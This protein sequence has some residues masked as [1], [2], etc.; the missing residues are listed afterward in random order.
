M[1]P[2]TVALSSL[3]TAACSPTLTPSPVDAGPVEPALHGLLPI[4]SSYLDRKWRAEG[5]LITRLDDHG[6]PVRFGARTDPLVIEARRFYDTL[7]RPDA[8]TTPVDY[9]DPFT[10]E[11]HITRATAPVSLDE[12]KQTFGFPLWDRAGGEPLARYRERVRAVVYYNKHELGLG[13]ELACATFADGVDEG[14]RALTGIACYVTN[15]GAAFDDRHN[16]LAAAVAGVSPKNTVCITY[17]PSFEPGYQVQFYVYAADGKRLEWAEL[18]GQGPRPVPH[19]CMSCHG[20][21]Y[22]ESRHLAKYARFLPVD[23]N[24]LVFADPVS[25]DRALTRAGQEENMRIVNVMSLST[26]LTGAQTVA[27]RGLYGG[28]IEVPGT[29]ARGDFVPP[30]WAGSPRDR[31]MFTEVVKPFC[32]TCHFAD[33]R[34]LDGAPL[35][36]Y[37]AL[38]SARAM[39]G[40]GW[41]VA[42]VCGTFAMPN[43]RPTL[44]HFWGATG[45]PV[46]VDDRSYAAPVDAFLSVWGLTRN[47]CRTSLVERSDCRTIKSGTCGNGWSGQVCNR[48]SGRCEP[49]LYASPPAADTFPTGACKLDGTQRCIS[50]Q[51][52]RAGVLVPGFDGAC[53]TCGREAEPVC[54]L[55]ARCR[56]GLV[57]RDGTCSKE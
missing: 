53:F 25:V 54:T 44:H 32:G 16:A 1:K 49:N 38:T 27:L 45:Q 42:S 30:E 3:L 7:G 23:P 18:D 8:V 12:W 5:G 37:G 28:N 24:L 57:P 29:V 47:D 36:T 21:A 56:S 43:A 46:S 19:I 15:Y 9:A 2:V 52:C 11:L 48:E 14:G 26:P 20:G 55:G 4:P 6:L 31:S 50:G 41:L 40:S 17:R 35:P 33:E 10:G 22:D 13:R 34:A 51:E 39:A